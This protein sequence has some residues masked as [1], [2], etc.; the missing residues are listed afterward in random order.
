MKSTKTNPKTA[1]FS[2]GK[3]RP[4]NPKRER[5]S[6]RTFKNLGT[7]KKGQK[8][9]PV[10]T[11]MENEPNEPLSKPVVTAVDEPNSSSSSSSS[12]SSQSSYSSAPNTPIAIGLDHTFDVPLASSF[13]IEANRFLSIINVHKIYTNY[14]DPRWG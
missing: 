14:I 4:S 3:G 6:Q 12:E 7:N 5:Q 11:A 2:K 8:S 10:I 9:G 1:G 13:P